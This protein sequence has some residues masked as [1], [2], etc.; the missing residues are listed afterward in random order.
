MLLSWKRDNEDPFVPAPPREIMVGFSRQTGGFEMLCITL[1]SLMQ[2]IFAILQMLSKQKP[3]QSFE[4]NK[5]ESVFRS[6]W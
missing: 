3:N 6:V 2:V 5:H 1:G 4:W